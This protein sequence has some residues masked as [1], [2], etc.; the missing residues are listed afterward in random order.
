MRQKE[1]EKWLKIVIIAVALVGIHFRC[2]VVQVVL[3]CPNLLQ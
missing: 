3:V 1:L 2:F